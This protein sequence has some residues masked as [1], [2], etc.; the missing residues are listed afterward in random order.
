MYKENK[1]I[2][3]KLTEN[4]LSLQKLA[5]FGHTVFI[6]KYVV[7]SVMESLHTN[8]KQKVL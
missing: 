4:F 6:T 7:I 3:K 2:P 8:N 1:K 5:M